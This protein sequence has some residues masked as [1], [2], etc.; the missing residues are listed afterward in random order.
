MKYKGYVIIITGSQ[1]NGE[2]DTP[3]CNT[4]YGYNI[5]RDGVLIYQ[6]IKSNSSKGGAFADAELS[7]DHC[8][9]RGRL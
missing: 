2:F 1:G 8:I 7:I 5:K 3:L 6:R 9:E 4:P